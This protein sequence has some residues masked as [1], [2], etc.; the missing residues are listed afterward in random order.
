MPVQT[1]SV[2]RAFDRAIRSVDMKDQDQATAA[3]ARRLA[4][5]IDNAQSVADDFDSID[6]DEKLSQTMYQRIKAIEAKVRAEQVANDLAPKLI[7]LLKELGM[8]PA[9]RGKEVAEDEPSTGD[10]VLARLRAV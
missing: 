10:T 6:L 1:A 8:T 4:A 7:L 9:A 3:L 2:L 5:L